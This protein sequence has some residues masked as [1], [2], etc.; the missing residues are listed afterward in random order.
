MAAYI[1]VHG[2][3]KDPDKMKEYGTGASA[4]LKTHGAEVVSRA[5]SETLAGEN[6]HNLTVILK[7]PT[8][9]AAHAW[10]G[11]AEYQALIPTREAAMDAVFTL[12]GDD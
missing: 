9:A 4:T 12:T 3:I 2:T 1:V 8:C 10:Y 7:F 11:S 5:G 6:P